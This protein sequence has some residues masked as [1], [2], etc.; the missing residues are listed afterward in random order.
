[1]SWVAPWVVV[2]AAAATP[3]VEKL[4]SAFDSKVVAGGWE[5]LG[6]WRMT[7]SDRERISGD[8]RCRRSLK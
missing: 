3:A 5:R 1:M 6:T 7:N 4:D 8:C 2:A